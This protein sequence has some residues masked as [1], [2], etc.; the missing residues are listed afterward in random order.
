MFIYLCLCVY[1]VVENPVLVIPILTAIPCLVSLHLN[2]M[3]KSAKFSDLWLLIFS[4]RD[5]NN[6]IVALQVLKCTS[7]SPQ[8]LL[9]ELR[10]GWFGFLWQFTLLFSHIFNIFGNFSFTFCLNLLA[11]FVADVFFFLTTLVLPLRVDL[12]NA[13]TSHYFKNFH[14][15]TKLNLCSNVS[16]TSWIFIMA[17]KILIPFIHSIWSKYIELLLCCRKG[18]KYSRCRDE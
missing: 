17:F 3:N 8:P 12:Q 13:V 1:F 11:L 15:W 6:G 7:L 4:G 14:N 16:L 18:M 9:E 2:L 10:I 5:G